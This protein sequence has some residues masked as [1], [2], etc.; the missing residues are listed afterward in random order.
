M[1]S[2]LTRHR[3]ESIWDRRG[4]A[5]FVLAPL[6]PVLAYSL[7]GSDNFLGSLMFG[8]AIAYAHV[9]VLGLPLAAWINLRRK[10]SLFTSALGAACI[11]LLPWLVFMSWSMFHSKGP[12]GGEAIV[13]M[14]FSFGF[15]GSMGFIAGVVWWPILS[16]WGTEPA[17]E[18]KAS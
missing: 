13:A 6:A 10:I 17:I 7:F 9:L 1:L 14:F 8:A 3:E 16:L 4:A 2:F 12:M 18:A 5:A 15:F 11:G